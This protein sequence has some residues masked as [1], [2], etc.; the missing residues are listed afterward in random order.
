M[1][2]SKNLIFLWENFG[3][4]H[5]D[6]CECVN[7]ILNQ[8]VIGIELSSNSNTYDWNQGNQNS[9]EKV[10]LFENKDYKAFTLLYKLIKFRIKYGKSDWFLCHYE[11]TGIFLFAIFLRVLGD[12]VFTM[13]DSKFDDYPR[14]IWKELIKKIFM[15]PYKGALGCG[16]R[17]KDYL[18]FLGIPENKIM[19]EYDTLSVK[20]IQKLANS[21]PAPHG[22]TYENR[23]FTIVAR[24]VP[25]KN[26][27]MAIQAYAEY[28]KSSSSYRPLHICGSG[29]LEAELKDLAKSLNVDQDIIFHGFIQSEQIAKL[30]ATTLSLILPSIEEQFGLVVIEAQAMGLPVLISEVCGARD[31]LIRN[32]VNGFVFEPDNPEG[33]AWFM[34]LISSDQKL[35]QKMCEASIETSKKGDVSMFADGVKKLIEH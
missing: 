24:L 25:K 14:F 17:S 16:R 21:V 1:E 11:L 23:H 6:R 4:M 2:H 19:L 27:H 18:R 8:K 12:N 31:H 9:F 5:F 7:E 15:L 33:L 35:W 3:P 26:L 29:P 13:G 10:T 28:K 32:T 22:I 30:L 34:N 20:R